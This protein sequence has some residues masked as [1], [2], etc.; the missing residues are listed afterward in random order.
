MVIIKDEFNDEDE[1]IRQSRSYHHNDINEIAMKIKEKKIASE[2]RKQEELKIREQLI[3]KKENS[4]SSRSSKVS[5]E[6]FS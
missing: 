4:S 2:K 1:Q 5:F 3:K 6:C